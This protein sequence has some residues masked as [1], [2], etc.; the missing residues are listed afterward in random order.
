MCELDIANALTRAPAASERELKQTEATASAGADT[1]GACAARARESLAR[2][3][4]RA[5]SCLTPPTVTDEYE[6][7]A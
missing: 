3:A 6:P 7:A 1:A 2:L 4:V 5:G